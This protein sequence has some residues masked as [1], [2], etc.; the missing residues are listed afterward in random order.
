MY[1][2]FI[3][4]LLF[5]FDPEKIHNFVIK[6]FSM[7]TFLY[8]VFRLLYF[9]KN[10]IEQISFSGLKFRNRL[11][12]AAGFDK[13]GSAIKFWEALGFSHVEVGTVTPLP[14]PGNEKPRIFRLVK[15]K[16]IINRLGFNN[17][18][19]DA[20]KLNII[21]ARK[22]LSE[23]FI[24]GVNIGKNKTTPIESAYKDYIVCLRKLYEQAD[25]YTINISSPNTE[26]LRKLQ[27]KKYLNELLH[28]IQK[29]NSELS[30]SNSVNRKIIFLK[31]APDLSDKEIANIYS[32]A[33]KHK[34][35]GIIATNTTI[36]RDGLDKYSKE[37]G[38]LSGKPLKQLSDRVLKKFCD[39][40]EKNETNKLLLIGVGGV[41]DYYGFKNKL[42]IGAE[43]IQVYTGFIYEGPGIIKKL[44][45]T[46]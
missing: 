17:N 35:D 2:N 13:N 26:E 23:N 33:V 1:K 31:I 29:T 21:K 15:N 38:G 34:I 30:Q 25:Y 27:G 3:R 19:A 6:F 43:L 18:G 24:I 41:V 36:T 7:I 5:L 20:L 39:L 12:L 46:F 37:E 9:P 11:G 14:Q 22:S 42:N 40:N 10:S 44:L 16:A 45:N 32:L 4:P 8:P 28:E